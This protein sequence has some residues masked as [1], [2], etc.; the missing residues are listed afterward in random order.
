MEVQAGEE[1]GGQTLYML[2][3][4]V[5]LSHYWIVVTAPVTHTLFSLRETALLGKCLSS[6][7]VMRLLSLVPIPSALGALQARAQVDWSLVV[8]GHSLDTTL[9][10]PFFRTASPLVTETV[11]L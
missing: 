9:E 1:R 11:S 7:L 3:L 6:L 5:S 10:L 4:K 2:I 8:L